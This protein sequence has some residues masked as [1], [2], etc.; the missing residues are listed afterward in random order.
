MKT[1][2]EWAREWLSRVNDAGAEAS[3][4]EVVEVIVTNA[5]T[6]YKAM[7]EEI[8]AG[9]DKMVADFQGSFGDAVQPSAIHKKLKAFLGDTTATWKES[10]H[11]CGQDSENACGRHLVTWCPRCRYCCPECAREQRVHSDR[12]AKDI[13]SE[14][15]PNG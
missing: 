2:R 9:Y 1:P 12:K 6:P 7:L 14:R 10:A 8:L 3:S 13:S 11:W 15:S 4:Q 5:L